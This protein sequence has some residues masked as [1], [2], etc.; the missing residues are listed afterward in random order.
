[1]F[2]NFKEAID[3]VS[4]LAPEQRAPYQTWLVVEGIR[5]VAYYLILGIVVW[6]VGRRMIHAILAGMRESGRERA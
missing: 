3:A 4:K 2:E 6:A 5:D 1:M